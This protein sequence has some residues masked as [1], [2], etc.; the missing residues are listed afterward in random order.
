MPHEE[1]GLRH[2]RPADEQIA[3]IIPL[4]RELLS[5]PR[6]SVLPLSASRPPSS[7]CS[8]FCSILLLPGAG[9]PLLRVLSNLALP[10]RATL[11]SSASSLPVPRAITRKQ[12][13]RSS[14]LAREPVARLTFYF[15][16]PAHR[17]S[18]KDGWEILVSTDMTTPRYL[19]FIM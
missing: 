11:A 6:H 9:F 8:S 14:L 2:R 7:P 17:D 4:R 5:R 19:D 13:A 16:L 1:G 10:L 3:L 12:E 18:V 15:V